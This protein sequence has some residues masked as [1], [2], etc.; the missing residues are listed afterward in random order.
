MWQ[1]LF[2][3]LEFK[4]KL[5][6]LRVAGRF[7][8]LIYGKEKLT[9]DI[10]VHSAILI[11]GKW[12]NSSEGIWDVKRQ[13][14]VVSITVDWKKIPI[15]HLWQIRRIEN[16]FNWVVYMDVKSEVKI[17]K[18]LCGLM[19]RPDY[20]EW[21]S[22]V[23]EGKFPCFS[24]SWENIF[25]QDF[26]AKLL[27]VRNR[28]NFP[29]V[30]FENLQSGQLLL[31]NSPENN[32][33]RALRLELDSGNEHFPVNRYKPFN[34]NFYVLDSRKKTNEFLTEKSKQLLEQRQLI[35]G[36]L[37]LV[38]DHATIHLYWD[39]RKLTVNQGLYAALMVGGEWF[40]SSKAQWKVQRINEQ[41]IYIEIDWRPLP[42]QQSWQLIINNGVSFDWK[43]KTE[44][45][46]KRADLISKMSLGLVLDPDYKQ[47]LGGY[48]S[49]IFPINFGSWQEM[50]EDTPEGTIGLRNSENLPGVVFKNAEGYK[51][52][53]LVQ[54]A[55]KD[56]KARFLQSVRDDGFEFHQQ[57]KIIEDKKYIDDFLK[58]RIDQEILRGG[59]AIGNIK[60]VCGKGKVRLFWKEREITTDIGLHSA[61][62]SGGRWY[63]SGKMKWD[64]NKISDRKL[65]IDVD[66]NPFPAIQK[67]ELDFNSGDEFSWK[68]SMKLAKPVEITEHKAGIILSGAYKQWFNS[69]EDGNF[70]E[71]FSYWHDIIR[72]RDGETFGTYPVDGLPGFMFS[73]DA[74][75]QSLIQNT[76][77]NIKGRVFQGQ[78][79]ET[80][81][82]KM[83]PQKE[84]NCFSGI[85]KLVEDNKQIKEHKLEV[86]PL[87]LNSEAVYLYADNQVLH[88]RIAGIEEFNEKVKKINELNKKGKQLNITIGVSRYN[89]F[90]L[91]EI[92]KFVL[93]CNG[94]DIDLRSLKL[95]AFPL[96]RLRRNFIEYLEELK[97]IAKTFGNI[98]FTLIDQDLFKLITVVCAQANEGNERQL[99]RLLSVIC[100]H[101][102]IGPAIIVIDPYHRCN[103]NCIHC[104]V[105]TPG[106]SH[107][108]EY[109]EMKLDFDKFK[110]IADDLGDLMVDLIIFQGDG[111]PLM[112][113]G[114][115]EMVKY[116][117]EKG[118][119]VS[120]FTNGILLDKANA[121]N[122]IKNGVTEIFCSLPAGTAKTFAQINTKQTEK[123]FDNILSNLK[124]LCA[125]KNKYPNNKTR[126]IVTHVI[127]TMNAHE[128]L[129]MAKN[130]IEIGADVMRFYLIRLDKNIEFL[131]LKPEDMEKIKSSLAQIK[132]LIKG[133]NI[134]LLDTT[135]FQ[136]DN[137]EQNSG[138]W[139]GNIF[140]EKGCTL[141]WNF[142][143][144]PASG[145]V[146]FCCHL[147]TV[148]YLAEK[149]FKDIW[150]SADYK[151]FRYQ[152]KFLSENSQAKFLNGTSLFDGYCQNCDTHQVIRD[153]WDQ[154]KLYNL[155]EF[156]KA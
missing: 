8:E 41:C 123:T 84:F 70:P 14:D 103:A 20:E 153:V 39:E 45:K 86:Q 78:V 64:I 24:K 47:W 150:N 60:L 139:S 81:E 49:G 61:V 57:I 130:D 56:T 40:D 17:E 148:G 66:F 155:E 75:H 3:K 58:A 156:F 143:L 37:K 43:V 73:I 93:S 87:I 38:L 112:H 154:F 102:F 63:D 104:W 98:N 10:C 28:D 77:E 27:G 121:E 18:M 89:F 134:K 69:F 52:K 59:I 76:D 118:I 140:L 124:Y 16:G 48:E 122:A 106:V 100:E 152:A 83:Y 107:P 96:R 91:A 92:L 97:K 115:F 11:E 21:I 120:F 79:V 34:L 2:S 29:A 127:H 132:E 114:F 71:K 80:E 25:L 88:D 68:I 15:R 67:W 50:I 46:E 117:R 108:K 36:K 110:A 135:D 116:A 51:A 23:E 128:L 131:K 111:E 125:Y 6:K 26:E 1:R 82:T 13:N 141:G 31:Q 22:A 126:L 65:M 72:N 133:K 101:A 137:F 147:R 119:Q 113:P 55:D 7:L 44:L 9:N 105:H 149:G 62:C 99:L 138:S 85:I 35:E 146:S 5:L 32:Q 136:L 74:Q 151:R 129:E 42:I 12:H 90:N 30:I 145:A 54:N 94:Q 4:N 19:L 53:L 109:Y 142:C 33:S 95:N 144:I